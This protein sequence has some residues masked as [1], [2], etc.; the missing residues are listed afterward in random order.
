M[1]FH[2]WVIVGSFVYYC[3]ICNN[4]TFGTDNARTANTSRAR[5]DSNKKGNASANSE[6]HKRSNMEG[7]A[8]GEHLEGKET[9]TQEKGNVESRDGKKCFV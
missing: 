3:N 6:S 2:K 7:L 1:L 4:K 9:S 8:Q 5:D